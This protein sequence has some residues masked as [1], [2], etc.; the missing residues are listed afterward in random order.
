MV[1][2]RPAKI[3]CDLRQNATKKGIEK[4]RNRKKNE[5]EGEGENQ[6]IVD[7]GVLKRKREKYP[8]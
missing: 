1:N 4:K 2:E 6:E 5:E 7:G 3:F 8:A